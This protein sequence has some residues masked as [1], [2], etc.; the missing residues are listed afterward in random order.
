MAFNLNNHPI[1]H[2][3][4]E[5]LAQLDLKMLGI[6]HLQACNYKVIGYQDE[7]KFYDEIQ[8]IAPIDVEFV[9]SSLGITGKELDTSRWITLNF[10]LK[11]SISPQESESILN[12]EIREIAELTLVFDSNMNCIDENWLIY[13]ESPFVVAKQEKNLTKVG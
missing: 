2:E 7:D 3:Y 10:L 1:W 11:A 13:T 4:A 9:S 5:I 8:F 12:E 6:S